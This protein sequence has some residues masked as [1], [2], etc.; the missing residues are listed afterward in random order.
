[1]P[2]PN[3]AQKKRAVVAAAVVTEAGGF[4]TLARERLA[5]EG[6]RTSDGVET[7]LRT[8]LQHDGR[9]LL[10][11]LL[12]DPTLPLAADASGPGEK[13]T[14]AVAR[15]I[16]T[17]FGPLTL[18]RNYYHA[19]ATGQGRYP[20]DEALKLAGPYTDW[21][22]R[23]TS[24]PACAGR[25]CTRAARSSADS[26][27]P[28]GTVGITPPNPTSPPPPNPPRPESSHT[29]AHVAAS[30]CSRLAP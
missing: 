1:V 22:R 4:L 19:A 28:S 26:S 11:N 3:P 13:C 10:E 6:W 15:E 7:G 18:R 9:R 25:S 21:K 5:T 2:T 16:E 17:L 24:A 23:A 8:A 27:T 14:P 30:K 12:N 29:P 20:L